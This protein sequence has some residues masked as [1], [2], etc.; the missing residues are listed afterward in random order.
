MK[1]TAAPEAFADPLDLELRRQAP[2]PGAAATAASMGPRPAGRNR[3]SWTEPGAAATAVSMGAGVAEALGAL[4]PGLA[5]RVEAGLDCGFTG[6]VAGRFDSGFAGRV[7]GVFRTGFYVTGD[8]GAIFA[9]LGSRSWPGP[10]HLVAASLPVLPATG[11]HVAA[12]GATLVAGG[13]EIDFGGAR[14]WDPA[15]PDGLGFDPAV[16]VGAVP[17]VEPDLAGVWDEV[18]AAVHSGDL[19]SACRCLEG[20]GGG[21]T[22]TGDDTLAGIMLVTAADRFRR[23]ALR[24]LACQARTSELSRAF[25]EWAARGSS[26]EPAHAVLEA[27]ASGDRS[28]LARAARTLTGVGASSGRA[29]LAGLAL[30]VRMIR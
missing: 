3:R 4:G 7:A 2:E 19:T 22:P 5:G 6:R 8:R 12:A 13:L 30:A 25:L 27:A 28:G 21:L 11:E 20:R 18:A 1:A 9:V 26:I 17:P 10:L 15:L 29:L 24:R 14:L 16:W 23:P